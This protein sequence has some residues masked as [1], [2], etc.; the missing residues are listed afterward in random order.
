MERDGTPAVETAQMD[1]EVHYSHAYL[2]DEDDDCYPD[3]MLDDS[4]THPVG[5]IRVEKGNAFLITGLHTGTVSFTVAVADQD[6]GADL[7]GYE[8]I[9]E[10]SF[11]SPSG[12][13]SLY[14]SGGGGVHGIPPLSAGSGTYRFRYHARGMDAARETSFPDTVIDHYLLQIWPASHRDPVILKSTS[15]YFQD[16]LSAG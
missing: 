15:S 13:V 14:E 5:I 10:I 6:P 8:D 2:L 4:P 7:E 16:W 1:V 11:E 3:G 12:C 9:V